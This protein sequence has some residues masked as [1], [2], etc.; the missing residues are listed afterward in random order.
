[1]AEVQLI[2]QLGVALFGVLLQFAGT[3]AGPRHMLSC[4]YTAEGSSSNSNAVLANTTAL[5]AMALQMLL[6]QVT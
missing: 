3:P 5:V 4:P 2:K 6:Y 1:V